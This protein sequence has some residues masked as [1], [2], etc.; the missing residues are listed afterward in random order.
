[1][2]DTCAGTIHL[3][4][5]GSRY[6]P[7]EPAEDTRDFEIRRSR[8][9]FF[10]AVERTLHGLVGLVFRKEPT[11]GD[12]A[13]DAIRGREANDTAPKLA[14]N[15]RE[16]ADQTRSDRLQGMLAGAGR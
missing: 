10:N 11:L 7:I 6:L 15:G 16:R 3:R 14:D 12:D 2:R 4:E 8:A 1:M 9:I 13:P 5:Q